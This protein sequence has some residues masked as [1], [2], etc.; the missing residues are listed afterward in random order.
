MTDEERMTA[1]DRP[2]ETATPKDPRSSAS[3]SAATLIRRLG[4]S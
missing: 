1:S 3:L 4:W 2:T